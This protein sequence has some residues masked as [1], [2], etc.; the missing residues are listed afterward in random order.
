MTSPIPNRALSLVLPLVL[1]G[2]GFF[3]PQ[4][5]TSGANNTTPSEGNGTSTESAKPDASNQKPD[6]AA[7]LGTDVDTA[8]PKRLEALR[9]GMSRDEIDALLPGT[10]GSKG[11]FVDARLEGPGIEKAVV[12]FRDEKAATVRIIFST[13]VSTPALWEELK[14]VASAKYGPIKPEE[15]DKDHIY[16]V[17][18]KTSISRAKDFDKHHTIEFEL[19]EHRANDKPRD[20]DALIGKDKNKPPKLFADLKK[21]MSPEEIGKLYPAVL[22]PA[23]AKY[24]F[25]EIAVNDI[26]GVRALK[27]YFPEKSG[28]LEQ[29]TIIFRRSASQ[30]ADSDALYDYLVAKYGAKKREEHV[31]WSKQQISMS[32]REDFDELEWSMF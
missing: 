12:Y 21:G 1:A 27:F 32:D 5:Q 29:A 24:A 6:L 11:A 20:L 2:C 28:K 19:D 15:A 9:P 22:D 16:W 8:H 26:P 4:T 10:K 7:L 30:K 17:G 23:V 25:R 3:M 18:F 31:Y 13:A 14:T